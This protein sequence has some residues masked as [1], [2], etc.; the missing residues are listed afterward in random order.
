[1]LLAQFGAVT[2]RDRVA[3]Q[4]DIKPLLGKLDDVAAKDLGLRSAGRQKDLVITAQH[5]VHERFPGEVVGQANL[6]AFEDVPDTACQW[7]LL[8]LEKLFLIAVHLRDE[9]IEEIHFG[10]AADV[11]LG[12]L[13]AL[14][15]AAFAPFT[16]LTRLPF[17]RLVRTIRR[18]RRRRCRGQLFQAFK[19]AGQSLQLVQF[20]FRQR[21][22]FFQD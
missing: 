14:L 7:V 17:A 20:G 13:F 4:F 15:G 9:F 6:P 22:D 12:L 11:V 21:L 8:R 5:G 2:E 18:Q 19:Q 3:G 16:A 1:M 10:Q